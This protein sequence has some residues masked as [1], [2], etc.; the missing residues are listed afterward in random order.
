MVASF[1]G[2]LGLKRAVSVSSLVQYVSSRHFKSVG[3]SQKIKAHPVQMWL[4]FLPEFFFMI[5]MQILL[6]F[7]IC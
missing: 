5:E 1:L 4:D 2:L 7:E 6:W 3:E